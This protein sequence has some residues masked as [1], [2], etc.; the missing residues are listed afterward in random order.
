[1]P[2]AAGVDKGPQGQGGPHLK[3]QVRNLWDQTEKGLLEGGS[4]EVA[5]GRFAEGS[6][7]CLREHLNRLAFQPREGVEIVIGASLPMVSAQ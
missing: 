1:M 3:P 5:L 2:L 7:T 6:L 4:Q